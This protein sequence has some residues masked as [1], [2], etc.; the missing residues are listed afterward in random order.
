MHF[1]ALWSAGG[2]GDADRS[3]I[4]NQEVQYVEGEVGVRQG[5]GMSADLFNLI[6]E[7]VMRLA[8]RRGGSDD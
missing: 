4:V 2:T 7:I 3:H 1:E 8:A 5:C 6:L